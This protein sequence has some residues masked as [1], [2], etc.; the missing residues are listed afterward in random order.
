MLYLHSLERMKNK[1][2]NAG[3]SYI[4]SYGK[5][6]ESLDEELQRYWLQIA[7]IHMKKSISNNLLSSSNIEL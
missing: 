4:S 5:Y 3:K 1:K 2:D 7:I 6:R